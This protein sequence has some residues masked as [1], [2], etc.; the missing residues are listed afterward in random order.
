MTKYTHSVTKYDISS[1]VLTLEHKYP[2]GSDH[3][4]LVD[5]KLLLET[6]ESTHTRIGEW[7]NIIGYVA[8]A[9]PSANHATVSLENATSVQAVIFWS[10]GS[11]KL[12]EYEKCLNNL[13][14]IV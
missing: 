4:A 14:L 9:S 11:I 12:E 8:R 3:K 7:V 5:V 10:A 2:P 1:A 6:L 13:I